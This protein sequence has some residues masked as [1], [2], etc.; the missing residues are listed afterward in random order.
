VPLTKYEA[1]VNV[2]DVSLNV[3]ED[4]SVVSVLQVQY[5][6]HHTVP[7]QRPDEVVSGPH[8]AGGAVYPKEPLEEVQQ[9]AVLHVLLAEHVKGNSVG[10]GFNQTT[11]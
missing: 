3:Q 1:I 10:D 5:V 9:R 2:H 6:A 8:E 4:V 7:C 11:G